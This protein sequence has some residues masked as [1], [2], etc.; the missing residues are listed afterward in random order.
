MVEKEKIVRTLF[1]V[2]TEKQLDKDDI[3]V[4]RFACKSFLKEKKGWYYDEENS[5]IEKGVSGFKKSSKER[6]VVQNI[7]IDANNGDFDV[8]LVYMFDRIGRQEYDTPFILKTLDNMGVELWSVEEGRQQF[9]DHSDDLINFIR[10]WQASGESKKTS[11]RVK[12]SLK[13]KVLDGKFTGGSPSYGYK[14]VKSGEFNKKGKELMML[15][16]DTAEAKIVSLIYLLSNKKGYGGNRIAKYLNE[17][18]I[19]TR[20]GYFWRATTVDYILRNPIYKGYLVSSKTAFGKNGKMKTNKPNE[21]V[22][23]RERVEELVIIR[24]D[25]WE[26]VQKQRNARN[27]RKNGN[28]SA[29]LSVTTKS[30]LLLTGMGL[31]F[32]GYCGSPL[33][34]TYNTKSYT[35][36]NGEVVKRRSP[37]YRCSG[38][39]HKMIKC[40]GQTIYSHNKIESVFLNEISKFIEGFQEED[41][42]KRIRSSIKK[43]EKK[44]DIELKEQRRNFS[45][46]KK[47]LE[48]LHGEVVKS[49]S[50]E[51][52]FS[53]E[54]LNELINKKEMNIKEIENKIEEFEKDLQKEKDEI[55]EIE[56]IKS[57][58]PNWKDEFDNLDMPEK[59]MAL[60]KIIKQ[61]N[62]YRE[63]IRIEFSFNI[64]EF[65]DSIKSHK[66]L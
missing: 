66:K 9:K 30:P 14:L 53:P 42:E 40:T 54:L 36:K 23:S 61:V 2:S 63:E 5:Y 21:W 17:N 28:K 26:E 12:E 48:V 31:I 49:L 52:S 25:I 13:Q 20:N 60:N 38:K 37:K 8:L 34:T 18:D 50:G 29:Q 10:F 57:F 55:G 33:T 56:K 64:K 51:S 11:L 47:E 19:K 35:K 16:M 4:Q 44:S 6:D 3:P 41:L 27:Y 46:N 59:K 39:A 15:V 65:I 58:I 22:Q 24:E 45:K 1:R 62:V 7:L 32:C 43:I